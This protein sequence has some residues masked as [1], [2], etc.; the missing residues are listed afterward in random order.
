V[1]SY[2]IRNG[3]MSL[4]LPYMIGILFVQFRLPMGSAFFQYAL[5][6][7]N[8]FVLGWTLWNVWRVKQDENG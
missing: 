5:C 1:F 7:Y 3:R 4:A 8:L 2:H 6:G